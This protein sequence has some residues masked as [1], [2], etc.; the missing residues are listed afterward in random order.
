MTKMYL[1]SVELMGW[2][3]V[4]IGSI[5]VESPG[6]TDIVFVGLLLILC[7]LVGKDILADVRANEN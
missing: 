5:M 1:D 7:G 2:I 4:L 3:T 6:E